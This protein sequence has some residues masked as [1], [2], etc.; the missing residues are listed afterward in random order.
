MAHDPQAGGGRGSAYRGPYDLESVVDV[1][2]RVFLE[3]GYDATSMEQL[4][5]AAGVTKSA[6]YYHVSGKEELLRRGLDRALT[7]LFA[8]LDEP[9]SAHGAAVDRLTHVLR[10]M[11]EVEVELLPEVSVLLHSR[12]NS[13]TERDALTRRRVFDH[14]VAA[15][16]AEAAAEGSV[17]ADLDPELA[18]RLVIGMVTWIVEWYRPGGRLSGSRVADAILA[19]VLDGL[20]PRTAAR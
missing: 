12:G 19:I 1:A 17:R 6:F 5:A 15:L 3:R 18:A 8:I 14:A 13:E 2:F 16:L 7:A 20:R 9:A 10:R 11:V 4:A